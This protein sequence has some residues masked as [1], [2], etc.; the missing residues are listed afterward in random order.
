MIA[1]P[2]TPHRFV[3]TSSSRM[4]GKA[5]KTAVRLRAPVRI[6]GKPGTGKTAALLHYRQQYDAVYVECTHFSK[7]VGGLFRSLIAAY[8]FHSDSKFERDLTDVLYSRLT[9][10]AWDGKR[11]RDKPLFV[12]EWQTLEATA[13]RE[14]VRIS[15]NCG[16]PLVLSGNEERLTTSKIDHTAMAQVESRIAAVFHTLPL[17]EADCDTICIDF[18]VEGKD[19]FERVRR[20]G[21]G[22]EFRRLANV[23]EEAKLFREG[24][25]GSI[26]AFHLDEAI[27]SLNL[28]LAAS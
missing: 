5:I 22:L 18:N 28:H 20:I 23:L 1:V 13:Q 21:T 11:L 9:G 6:I 25:A 8:G 7:N 15:E 4:V 10:S 24:G 16:I 17:T 19:A 27:E 2:K 3:E 12:D 26:R 14:L